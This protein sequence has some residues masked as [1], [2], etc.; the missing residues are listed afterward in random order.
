MLYIGSNAKNS[1]V[2]SYSLST[3]QPLH[4]FQDEYLSHPAGMLTIDDSLYVLS[5]DTLAL[6]RFS[7]NTGAFTEMLISGLPDTPEQIFLSPC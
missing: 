3:R 7:T 2:Y 1:A 5:Q 4:V 6:L